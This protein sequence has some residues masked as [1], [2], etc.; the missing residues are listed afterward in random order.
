MHKHMPYSTCT[1]SVRVISSSRHDEH[2][3]TLDHTRGRQS[4]G[5]CSAECSASGD[6]RLGREGGGREGGGG[7]GR[8]GRE[9]EGGREG[10]D[11]TIT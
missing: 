8:E 2:R 7:M 1:Y 4:D 5:A 3:L 9:R 11:R 6:Q 10:G